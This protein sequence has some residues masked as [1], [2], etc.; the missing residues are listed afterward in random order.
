M[1]LL[2]A[3]LASVFVHTVQFNAKRR[4]T[5]KSLA[6]YVCGLE[7]NYAFPCRFGKFS[8]NIFVRC[9]AEN[10]LRQELMPFLVTCSRSL[11]FYINVCLLYIVRS[12][13]WVSTSEPVCVYVCA[14]E[15]LFVF[16]AEDCVRVLL[17]AIF[18]YVCIYQQL[19]II[20]V[21]C[22]CAHIPAYSQH[23]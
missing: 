7:Y 11:L 19:H 13:V 1:C 17:N 20:F 16:V 15:R 14:H 21:M 18:A 8:N 6:L 3:I 4:N 22:D 5:T 12:R 10:T 9:I 23:A 2:S